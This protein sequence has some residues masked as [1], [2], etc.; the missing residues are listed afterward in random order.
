VRE[1]RQS[2]VTHVDYI[3][4]EIESL[5]DENASFDG[6]LISIHSVIYQDKIIFIQAYSDII[7]KQYN[8]A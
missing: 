8:R 1:L 2:I 6:F 5:D 4:L 3:V 7:V